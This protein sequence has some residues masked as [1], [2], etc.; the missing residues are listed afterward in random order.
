MGKNI[1]QLKDRTILMVLESEKEPSDSIDTR[2]VLQLHNF[3]IA[4]VISNVTEWLF[5]EM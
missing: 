2:D 3:N 4:I 5:L 1:K